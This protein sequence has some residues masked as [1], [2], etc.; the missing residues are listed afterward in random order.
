MRVADA[1]G[2]GLAGLGV[3]TVFGVVGSGNFHVTNALVAGGARFVAARHEG[4]ATVM[5]DAWARTTG[6]PGVVTVHQGP[7]LTNAMTGI[8]E[9]A[10][11]RTP[12]LVLAAEAPEVRSN[13]HVDVA[14]LAAGVGAVAERLYSPAS[15]L[16]DAHRAY[17]TALGRRTVVLALPLNI[18]AAQYQLALGDPGP[19]PMLARMFPAAPAAEAVT[20]LA[21]VLRAARRPVFIAG[22]GARG[23]AAELER[24]ADA[25]GALL[26]TSAVAKGLFHGSPWN[27]DVSGGFASPLAAELIS[28][29]DVIV[30][31]GCAL[32][33]WTT[34]HGRLIPPEAT[35]V[36]VDDDATA[37]GAHR[38]VH[39]GVLGDVAET[40]RAV[41]A[42]LG[43]EGE[44]GNQGGE[45]G[46]VRYEK[47]LS[48]AGYRS[49]ELRERIAD[50]VRW[51]DV[52]YEGRGRRGAD[53][54]AHAVDR[55]G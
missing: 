5:A 17:A 8:A 19:M 1:V 15:A 39:L 32:N 14:G 31:W 3:N 16:A 28:G 29:A 46:P 47:S 35:L 27:L 40:A 49:A 42:A 36:Q 11:S 45:T 21:D 20:A 23:R 9:A 44:R 54:P 26:A 34:R 41:A 22:R 2:R 55:A 52:A 18:Q 7:G 4:G 13:F 48:A 51:R 50:Q 37:I 53:R 12:L 30:G 43:T 38:P 6:A 25:C 24:L 33:M 10:K